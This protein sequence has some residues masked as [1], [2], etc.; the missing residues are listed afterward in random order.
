MFLVL[1]NTI[2]SLTVDFSD[3]LFQKLHNRRIILDLKPKTVDYPRFRF[4]SEEEQKV[5]NIYMRMRSKIKDSEE[6][7][8]KLIIPSFSAN[9]MAKFEKKNENNQY[10]IEFKIKEYEL[11]PNEYMIELFQ[12]PEYCI[13]Y[14]INND[15]WK[16]ARCNREDKSQIFED[17]E[18]LDKYKSSRNTPENYVEEF[19]KSFVWPY[20]GV[21]RS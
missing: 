10:L 4:M 2:L 5:G 3:K 18:Y 6:E 12:K 9:G 8:M 15:V 21:S 13:Q 14:V 11:E 16:F 19:P 1:I 7:E 20:F 17:L